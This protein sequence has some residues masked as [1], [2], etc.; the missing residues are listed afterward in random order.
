MEV[1]KFT[2]EFCYAII[3]YLLNCFNQEFKVCKCN[4][5]FFPLQKYPM[6]YCWLI[7][8]L[9]FKRNGATKNKVPV[10]C[11]FFEFEP[12]SDF[13]CK[14]KKAGYTKT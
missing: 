11:W 3:R 8:K 12:Q 5:Y 7:L 2:F 10:P 9:L 1:R 6:K 14:I 13:L 4:F